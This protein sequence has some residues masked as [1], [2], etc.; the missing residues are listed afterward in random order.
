MCILNIHIPPHMFPI[1]NKT[2]F[3]C[4]TN[5]R[6]FI[7]TDF[8]PSVSDD[9]LLEALKRKLKKVYLK[10]ATINTVKRTHSW[11]GQRGN[12]FVLKCS[13]DV[14]VYDDCLCDF[15]ISFEVA[16]ANV[17]EE[18]DV[19]ASGQ[20]M[21]VCMEMML[22]DGDSEP[23]FEQ[24]VRETVLPEFIRKMNLLN[25]YDRLREVR[26]LSPTNEDKT[27]RENEAE[28]ETDE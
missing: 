24:L 23:V 11:T 15:L 5:G 4:R 25:Y 28:S 14:G 1:Y 18:L 8:A 20:P 6:N 3:S 7:L 10:T 21:L 2:A 16:R 13:K 22:P 27:E 12:A 17:V 26:G 19:A 9:E